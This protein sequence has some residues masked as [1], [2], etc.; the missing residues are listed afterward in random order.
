VN[1]KNNS[2]KN[3]AIIFGY[4]KIYYLAYGSLKG[5]LGITITGL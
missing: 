3:R 1:T 5:F 2:P 4:T